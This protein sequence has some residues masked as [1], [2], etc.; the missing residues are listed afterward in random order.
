MRSGVR[1]IRTKFTSPGLTHFGGIYLFH[2]FLQQLKIRSYLSRYLPYAQQ[3]NRYTLSEMILSLIY[4]VILGL[5][6]IEVSALLKTNGV[7]QFL[8]GLPSS[9]DPTALRRFLI[10]SSTQALPSLWEVHN[11]LKKHFIL[12]PTARSG[13]CF[14]FD[15]T[16]KTLYGKQEGVVKGYNPGHPGR[17]SYQPGKWKKPYRYVVLR[18]IVESEDD[19][20]SLH[21][22]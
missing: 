4:P 5:E 13:F 12:Q 3:N 15:S 7:F 22:L 10:R 18:R 20:R 11:D 21:F 9:P 2:Q 8:T 16:A 14:D 19:G 1:K 17:K 6:K